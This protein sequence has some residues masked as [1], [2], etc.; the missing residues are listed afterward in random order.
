MD[1][2]DKVLLDYGSLV[3]GERLSGLVCPKCN[4]GV[5][6]DRAFSVQ[7]QGNYL[8][9]MCFRASCGFRGRLTVGP[10]SS[11]SINSSAKPFPASTVI[12][13]AIP[14]ELEEALATKYSVDI[15]M[16]DW[17]KWCYTDSYKGAGPRVGMPILDPDG[18]IRGIVWRSHDGA[19]PKALTEAIKKGEMICWYRGRRHGKVLV[20]VEDQPSALRVASQGV[21]AVALC[22]TLLNLDRIYEIKAQGYDTVYLCLDADATQQ[23]IAHAVAY[24]A[25]LPALKIMELKDDIKDMDA[26][27]FELFIQ[28]VTSK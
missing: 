25:R 9:F 21:D 20:I 6:R 3:D 14:T 23:A 4:G 19:K 26:E 11:G 10:S 16:F 18:D 7:R 1:A 27:D 24:K 15:G 12:R 22:G 13:R 28:E 17:A 2:R 5:H 8:L